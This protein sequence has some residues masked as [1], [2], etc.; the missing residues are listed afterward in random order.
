MNLFSTF[1]RNWRSG[2]RSAL[3][4]FLTHGLTYL[5]NR[6]G[7]DLTTRFV[8]DVML[9]A[10]TRGDA[11]G[12]S[13]QKLD[14]RLGQNGALRW[15][16]Q[17]SIH[18]PEGVKRPDILLR[19]DREPLIVLEGKLSSP[20]SDRQ[21][22][23]YGKWLSRQHRRQTSPGAA[24]VFLTHATSPPVDYLTDRNQ[25]KYG[26]PLRSVSSWMEV[27]NFLKTRIPSRGRV[28]AHL[29]LEFAD[30]MAQQK[31]NGITE[32]DTVAI[33]TLLKQGAGLKIEPLVEAIRARIEP[34]SRGRYEWKKIDLWSHTGGHAVWDW[35]Y[36]KP[37][38]LD[39]YVAWGLMFGG[40]LF[41]IKLPHKLWAFTAVQREQNGAPIP[42]RR[43][44]TQYKRGLERFGWK[45][46]PEEDYDFLCLNTIDAQR[47]ARKP[48]GFTQSLIQWIERR[49]DEAD[50]ILKRCDSL[51]NTHRP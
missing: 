16:S 31:L 34:R 7:G 19:S 8:L 49:F 37:R 12:A 38:R 41:E 6:L 39:W 11:A 33:R 17:P 40:E 3:E 15:E 29:T 2:D 22:E 36:Y 35:C 21:L 24:L 51:R 42:I 48:G 13:L 46:F 30:F 18:L 45:L 10:H 25:R 14:K 27:H 26:V 28:L 4:P 50:E 9:N 1:Y 23:F 43:L 44:S 20:L 32:D 5:L 47:L